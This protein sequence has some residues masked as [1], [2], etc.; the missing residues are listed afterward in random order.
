MVII[1]IF[2]F[3][4]NKNKNRSFILFW[5]SFSAL[6]SIPIYFL[7]DILMEW[8]KSDFDFLKQYNH[9]LYGVSI[10]FVI[11]N[12]LLIIPIFI[13]SARSGLRF[14]IKNYNLV[15]GKYEK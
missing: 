13:Y 2:Y 9:T 5:C 7:S 14:E 10:L 6:C 4:S 11:F 12:S 15:D 8:D 3:K 1:L